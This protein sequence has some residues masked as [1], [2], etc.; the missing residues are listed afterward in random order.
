MKDLGLYKKF[1]QKP[2]KCNGQLLGLPYDSENHIYPAENYDS[3]DVP[4]L[5]L[6]PPTAGE[7]L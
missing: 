7:R 5:P 3:L 2:C 1:Y 6:H 4:D